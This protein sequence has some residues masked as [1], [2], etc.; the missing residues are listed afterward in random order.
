MNVQ[1]LLLLPTHENKLTD[2]LYF[3]KS[4]LVKVACFSGYK[5]QN[6]N[7]SMIV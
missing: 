3:I 7:E 2:V 5:E 6:G 1:V 4:G